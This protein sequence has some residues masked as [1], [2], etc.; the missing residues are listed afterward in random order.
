[1][2]RKI[3]KIKVSHANNS[4]GGVFRAPF[5]Q[6]DEKVFTLNDKKYYD[7]YMIDSKISTKDLSI[8]TNRLQ[9][10]P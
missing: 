9:Y 8:F 3:R 10:F 7:Q 6:P 4:K 5:P 2:I 1:M